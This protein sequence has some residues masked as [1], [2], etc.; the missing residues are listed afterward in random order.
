MYNLILN[1]C[2]SFQVIER[3]LF[4]MGIEAIL[5]LALFSFCIGWRRQPYVVQPAPQQTALTSR[6][7][8]RVQ[9]RRK[10][11]K[12][13]LMNDLPNKPKGEKNKSKKPHQGH[14]RR[15]SIDATPPRPRGSQTVITPTRSVDDLAIRLSGLYWKFNTIMQYTIFWFHIFF[16]IYEMY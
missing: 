6:D 14:R 12:T 15:N 16:Q 8:T 5:F 13:K 1:I 9:R 11:S 3:H 4:L 2:L 7:F 10:D